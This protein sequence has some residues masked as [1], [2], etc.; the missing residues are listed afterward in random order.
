MKICFV[1]EHFYPHVG[2]VETVFF[3]YAK[4]L[5]ANGHEVKVIT[6]SSGG[7]NGKHEIDGF[8]VNYLNGCKSFFG[9]PLLPVSEI[10]KYAE[11]ADIIHTTTYTAALSAI[12]VSH[13][14]KKP[15]IITVH[16]VLCWRWFK[17][18]KNPIKALGFLFFEFFVLNKKFNCWHVISNATKKD[19]LKIKIPEN[20]MSL[21]YHGIDEILWN[22][23]VVPE[24]LNKYLGFDQQ[25]KIF[26][27]SGRPGKT[28]G[29]FLLLET[30]KKI[31][32]KLP[33]N[34]GFGFI[35]SNDPLKEK[36]KFKNLVKKYNLKNII[37]VADSVNMEK[38][39]GF[40]KSAYAAI[41]PSLTEGFGFNVAETAVLDIPI[42]SSNA[43]SLPEI[44]SGKVLFFKN[45]DSNDL[46]E[47]ILLA[48]E[49]K[50]EQTS[51]KIFSWNNSV[52][53]LVLLYENIINNGE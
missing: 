22:R 21:I 51:L 43:G 42:I 11:Q 39:P 45:G 18:E 2:G 49:G 34:F 29:I 37:R 24:N 31:K 12:K 26:L 35:L 48:I 8:E 6:S 16:E 10:K 52:K 30:I 40:R 27:Y 28:K 14:L 1:L 15:C 50:F 33:D 20:K 47:K 25:K 32:N 44:A 53:K 5:S 17:V 4:R 46:G 13:E 36:D 38:L 3:E 9:H 41:V 7:I 19:L 23:Y